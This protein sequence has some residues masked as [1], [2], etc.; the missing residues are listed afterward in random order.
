M[1]NYNDSFTVLCCFISRLNLDL[2]LIK[3][4]FYQIK[5]K[6]IDVISVY[7]IKRKPTKYKRMVK[8]KKCRPAYIEAQFLCE[9]SLKI[10]N[11]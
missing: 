2:L 6:N 10:Y 8:I 4:F 1:K 7:F 5:N 3:F 9:R 11:I